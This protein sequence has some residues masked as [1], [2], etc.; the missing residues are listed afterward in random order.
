MVQRWQYVGC[1]C[2]GDGAAQLHS[3]SLGPGLP[4]WSHIKEQP[5]LSTCAGW[6]PFRFL[7][8]SQFRRIH[9]YTKSKG[10][11]AMIWRRMGNKRS[12]GGDW[13]PGSSGV[14][15]YDCFFAVGFWKSSLR[16]PAYLRPM[17]LTFKFNHLQRGD[18]RKTTTDPPY[19]PAV[20]WERLP[21]V[22]QPGRD[23]NNPVKPST[24]SHT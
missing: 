14:W 23:P 24:S 16:S 15:S 20:K 13:D 17:T 5:C 18:I 6:S 7:L 22:R 2:V 12:G 3:T 4:S 11:E 8:C 9:T 19:I 10:G 21:C 1:W